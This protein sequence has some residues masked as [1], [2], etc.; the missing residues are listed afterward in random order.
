MNFCKACRW[1]C[2]TMPIIIIIVTNT[3]EMAKVPADTRIAYE[4]DKWVVRLT[5]LMEQQDSER[6]LCT[7]YF[8]INS[9]MELNTNPKLSITTKEPNMT[10][11]MSSQNGF[12]SNGTANCCTNRKTSTGTS[13]MTANRHSAMRTILTGIVMDKELC[14]TIRKLSTKCQ[15]N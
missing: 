3:M 7:W 12:H 13:K 10:K 9:T 2:S 11:K 8:L 4:K 5:N 15:L 6:F 14:N 1:N